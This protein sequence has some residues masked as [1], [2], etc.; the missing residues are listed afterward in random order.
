MMRFY[1]TIVAVVFSVLTLYGLDRGWWLVAILCGEIAFGTWMIVL[2]NKNIQRLDLEEVA[3]R[4]PTR[5][6]SIY[7]DLPD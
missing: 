4:T 3:R 5:Q 2:F 7:D 6:L 1:Y